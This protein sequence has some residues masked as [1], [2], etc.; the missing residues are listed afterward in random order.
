MV[1]A[2]QKVQFSN[3]LN[4]SKPKENGSHFGMV[5]TINRPKS[6]HVLYSSPH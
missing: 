2:S 5:R 1:W 6:K 3:G 4:Y